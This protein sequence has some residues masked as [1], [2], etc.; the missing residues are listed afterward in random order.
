M[1]GVMSI[2]AGIFGVV[3]TIAAASMG[4]GIFALFGII[5]IV[6]AISSAVYNLKNATSENRYS[7][8]DIVDS[9]IEPDPFNERF[10]SSADICET[11]NN[12]G[13]TSAFC[14]Y[15]GTPAGEDFE[16]CKSCG[17]KLP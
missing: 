15:C 6:A 9:E 16:F 5:F 12:D 2:L 10:G 11:D 4:G 13:S 7:S 3:W 17:K 1:S 14:P 8:F